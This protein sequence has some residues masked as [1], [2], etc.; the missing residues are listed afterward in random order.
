MKLGAKPPLRVPS[1]LGR[2]LAGEAATVM[3]TE[4]S[5]ASNAKARRELSWQPR[6]RQLVRQGLG[7]T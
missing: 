4:V 3:M 6:I 7:N 5:G 1:W 2:L